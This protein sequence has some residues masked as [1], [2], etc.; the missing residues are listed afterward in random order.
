MFNASHIFPF[1]FF[2]FIPIGRFADIFNISNKLQTFALQEQESHNK[3][4]DSHVS[5]KIEIIIII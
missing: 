2:F 5:T 4:R 3:G 1:I